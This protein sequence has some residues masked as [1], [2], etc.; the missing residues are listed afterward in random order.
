[1]PIPK[2]RPTEER[3]D[4]IN[5]CM[6]DDVMVDDFPNNAQRFAVCAS[7]WREKSDGNSRSSK[8]S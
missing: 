3:E 7:A 6:G 8:S 5:R 2:P 1:M 4:F